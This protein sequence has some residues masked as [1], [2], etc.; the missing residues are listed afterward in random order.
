MKWHWGTCIALFYL[1]FVS[2]LIFLVIRSRSF[3]NSLVADNYY[4]QDLQYQKHYDKIV[5][6]LTAGG[7][8]IKVDRKERQIVLQFP[9]TKRPINGQI[10]FYRPSDSTLD[11]ILPIAVDP[12]G[13]MTI[14]TRRLLDGQWEIKID[15]M[16]GGIANYESK[17]LTI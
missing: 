14:T 13:Q 9:E 2:I 15:W 11:L 7:V 6:N 10:H 5:N 1:A 3:D 8:Q 4:E 12:T 17:K 16:A